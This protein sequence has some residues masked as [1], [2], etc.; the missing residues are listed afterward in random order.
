MGRIFSLAALVVGIWLLSVMNPWR[1]Q[2]L[3]PNAPATQFS[4]ARANAVLARV[5]ADQ[6]P[7]PAGSAEAE[8]ARG[9]ILSELARMGVSARTQTGMSCYAERRWNIMPCATVTNIIAGVSP[10]AGKQVVLMAHSDSVAAGPGAGDDG[11]GVAILLETVRALKA[12]SPASSSEAVGRQKSG[13]HPI[14]AVFTDGEENGLLGA[15]LFLKD[16]LQRAK[17]GAVIN[18]EARGNQGPSYLFQTSKGNGP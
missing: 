11:S 6:H 15:N 2:A 8:A 4:A 18:A 16:P 1:P 13:E 14:L 10:G 12:R 5:L 17:T 7:H 3:E 9:R